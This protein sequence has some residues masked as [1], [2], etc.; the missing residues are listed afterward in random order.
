MSG[1]LLIPV[2]T[3]MRVFDTTPLSEVLTLPELTT[4]L[5]RFEI[6]L[7]T[8]TK[9][10]REI[11]RIQQA[12]PRV[13]A[14][15]T[16]RGKY[17]GKLA[18]AAE[19]ARK[20]GADPAAAVRALA[21]ELE[22][23]ARRSAKRDLRLWSPALYRPG[24]DKR[25]SESVTHV[26]CLVLDYDDGTPIA[27]ASV[28]WSS[29]FHLV[30]TTWS[31]TPEHPKFRLV[32]PLAF[33]V[34]AEDWSKVWSWAEEV[35]RFE[36]DPS[37]KSPA[38]NYALP[39]VPHRAWPREA[40][41]RPGAILDPV[42]E[43]IVERRAVLDLSPKRPPA[44]VPSVIRGEDPEHEYVDHADPEAVYFV[45][46]EWA[47]EEDWEPSPELVAAVARAREA[48]GGSERRSD[49]PARAE[50]VEGRETIPHELPPSRSREGVAGRPPPQPSPASG[51]GR[52]LR[53]LIDLSTEQ[54]D[55]LRAGEGASARAE[56]GP[57][58]GSA[59]DALE[60]LE[61]AIAR[62][63]AL[64]GGA[65][66]ASALERLVVLHERGWLSAE[67]LE[68]AKRRVL[69]EPSLE[70][71]E[72]RRIGPGRHRR[73]LAVDFDGVIHSY[74][75]GWQG[76]TAIAD[77]PVPGAID[78][79]TAASERFDLAIH[80]VRSAQPGAVDAMRAWLREHGL[81]ERVLERLR[82]PVA[83]PPAELYLDDRAYR[84]DGTFPS[85]DALA[86]LTPWT[87]KRG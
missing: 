57:P 42:D 33:P 2:C 23:D 14:G 16:P 5:R 54:G 86:E 17:M 38:A 69:S 18:K 84:F 63:E 15:E 22:E 7:S 68:A 48:D 58:G 31:H 78:W 70:P 80:S 56:G 60:R 53:E 11:A 59:P 87:R 55:T 75:S 49:A 76:P 32:M 12:A 6:K 25:G 34:P 61:A 73:T 29:W 47:D 4:A 65:A 77:P 62:V 1:P 35:A 26:S 85:F 3:F 72:L 51:G 44:G 19:K 9:I 30:H 46:E 21:A 74:A 24:A 83:K 43:G 8:T 41:S 64:A 67:E 71:G 79:L 28:T 50:G 36:I 40:F 66:I 27:D 81:P 13:I 20:E 10:D 37:M 82:F 52:P 45:D 39:A